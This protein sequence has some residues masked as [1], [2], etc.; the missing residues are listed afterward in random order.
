[1]N[2]SLVRNFE[3]LTLHLKLQYPLYSMLVVD[4]KRRTAKGLARGNFNFRVGFF[5][6][7]VLVTDIEN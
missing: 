7:S 6:M 5:S 2:A 3:A 4:S 1:M